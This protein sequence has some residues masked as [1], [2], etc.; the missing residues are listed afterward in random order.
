MRF[1]PTGKAGY[2]REKRWLIDN[3]GV[4]RFIGQEGDDA[5]GWNIVDQNGNVIAVGGTSF[6]AAGGRGRWADTTGRTR[7]SFGYNN[8]QGKVWDISIYDGAVCECPDHQKGTRVGLWPNGPYVDG[9]GIIDARARNGGFAACFG[10]GRLYASGEGWIPLPPGVRAYTAHHVGECV[11]FN[12]Q[13]WLVLMQLGTMRGKAFDGTGHTF[14]PDAIMVG[15]KYLV[16][17]SPTQSDTPGP[18]PVLVDVSEFVDLSGLSDD[19]GGG[20]G[21]VATEPTQCPDN[22]F[23]TLQ[24]EWAKELPNIQNET[25]TGAQIGKV[26]NATAWIH[27]DEGV[28]MQK[29][30]GSTTVQPRTGK[31]IW[32][33]I[34]FMHEGR[35]YGVDICGACS[36]GKFVPVQATPGPATA[37]SFV[38]PVEPEGEQP[39]VQ[40]HRYDGGA[41]DTGI[42]DVCGKSRFDPIHAIPESLVPHAY[43]GGEQDTGLCDICQKPASDP[44][45]T[46]QPPDH[47][48][49]LS[50]VYAAILAVKADL[51]EQIA[52]LNTRL[53]ALTSRVDKL[54]GQSV[55]YKLEAD[56]DPNSDTPAISTSSSWGHAHK[57]K[58]KIVPK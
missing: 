21:P 33:G 31:Q 7:S 1:S 18:D 2:G 16:G 41:N 6:L 37:D 26:I 3:L 8:D 43:D 42:C 5:H 46:S 40:T 58:A 57:L 50:E 19:A 49:D 29:K 13:R 47:P 14:Y 54:P 39:P 45:H 23:K 27:R 28:G 17:W 22:V 32:N 12:T 9:S 35:H 53:D 20:G 52:S 25:W 15:S 34:R 36:A 24:A 4:E 30:P 38:K 44:I 11:L 56:P 10:D 48:P 55:A 51:S